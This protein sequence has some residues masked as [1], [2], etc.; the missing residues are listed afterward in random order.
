MDRLD[1]IRGDEMNT[2]NAP[3]CEG[4]H[5]YSIVPS[6]EGTVDVYLNPAIEPMTTEDG[7]TDYDIAVRMVRG[8]NPND[9]QFGG[10]LEG[11]IR[12]HYDAWRD[13]GE[14][15]YL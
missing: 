10:D 4:R 5:F 13:S 15:I 7:I 1:G 3:P 6:G 12:A 2:A 9:P 14:M 8:V 11:H